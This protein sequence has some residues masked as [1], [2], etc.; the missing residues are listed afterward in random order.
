MTFETFLFDLDGTLIDSIE[1]ILSSYRHTMM[2]HR[3]SVPPDALWLEG[4]GTPV[5][6]QFRGFTDDP[7]EIDAFV[8]TYRA[9]NQRHHDRL[10]REYPGVS[11]AVRALRERG[12]RLAV[13]TSKLRAAAERG[14]HCCGMLHLFEVLVCADDVQNPKPDPEP[15]TRALELLQARP[16]DAIFIGDSVHDMAAGRA[17]GVQIAAALWGPFPRATLAAYSPDYWLAQPGDVTSLG[18]NLQ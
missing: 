13:V 2:T 3:G 11:D 4:L 17:A 8:A 12:A 16:R 15:V 7:D 9:H 6:V 18:A 5:R 10:I 14:L 1:L